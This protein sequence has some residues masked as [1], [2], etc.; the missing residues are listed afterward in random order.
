[1]T[2]NLC[3]A[4]ASKAMLEDAG[5]FRRSHPRGHGAL[6]RQAPGR[7]EAPGRVDGPG[8]VGLNPAM[9]SGGVWYRCDVSCFNRSIAQC[10]RC[11]GSGSPAPPSPPPLPT[12]GRMQPALPWRSAS[13]RP[14]AARACRSS[15]GASQPGCGVCPC[16]RAGRRSISST[17]G[18]RATRRPT[19]PWWRSTS[20]RRD[21]QQCAD[22]VIRLRAEWLWARGCEDAIAF[23]FTSGDLATWPTWRS[24]VAT[25][26]RGIAGQV[27]AGCRRG[28]QLR[29]ASGG[30]WTWSSPMPASASLARE[31]RPV[32]DPRS[33]EGGDVFIQGGHPGH[34][35]L[36]VDVAERAG[37]AGGSSCWPRAT[38]RPRRST[39]CATPPMPAVPGTTPRG[40]AS[41]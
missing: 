32:G 20:G 11:L 38:C 24:R 7:R 12:R 16:A 40:P 10:W 18:S 27:G 14:A 21:L 19:R 23:H 13:H 6:D 29:G 8:E 41:W 17:A 34:A 3:H 5:P 35:V 25:T 15:R 4:G 30:I 9:W 36:V 33:V 37:T 26:G 22:A 2:C 1:M 39:C 31:L 28:W